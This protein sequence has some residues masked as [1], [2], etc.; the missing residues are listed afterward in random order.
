MLANINFNENLKLFYKNIKLFNYVY[1]LFLILLFLNVIN[2]CF[3]L[4]IK[5]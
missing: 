3:Y 1:K 4:F 2:A 5:F